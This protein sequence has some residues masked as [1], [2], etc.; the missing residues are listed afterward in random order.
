MHMV[1]SNY[2]AFSRTNVVTK[3]SRRC[4]G[5]PPARLAQLTDEEA[6]HSDIG[7]LL[8]AAA[9]FTPT[10]GSPFRFVYTSGLGAERDPSKSIWLIKRGRLLKV[11]TR[12]LLFWIASSDSN[13]T[14]GEAEAELVAL[15]ERTP[16]LSV[17]ITRPALVWGSGTRWWGWF[18]GRTLAVH[19]DELAAVTVDLAL[20][21]A[22]IE[23]PPN[24]AIENAALVEHGQRLLSVET[25]DI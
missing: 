24:K 25:S 17:I 12:R 10:D 2:Q 19:N 5:N 4:I 6:R 3:S 20:G 11:S 18:V 14:Q 8:A 22:G 16:N 23:I 13:C 1:C 7:Y 21:G 15:G 9:A